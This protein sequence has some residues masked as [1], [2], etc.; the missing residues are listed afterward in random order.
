M[1]VRFF[2][3]KNIKIISKD[4]THSLR[5]VFI[6]MGVMIEIIFSTILLKTGRKKISYSDR[7]N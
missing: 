6:T 7:Q 2:A 3:K 5:L 1:E 4:C